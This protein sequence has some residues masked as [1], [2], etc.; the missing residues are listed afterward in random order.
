MSLVKALGEVFRGLE[1]QV[2]S[3]S[4][5]STA[6][7]FLKSEISYQLLLIDLEWRSKEGLKLARL[8][9]RLRHRNHLM[10]VLMAATKLTRYTQTVARKAGIQECIIKTQDMAQVIE[11]ICGRSNKET[12]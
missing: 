4:D 8:A 3:C 11:G 6:V 5:R 2:V 7:L 9:H 10:T 1:Y 12:N